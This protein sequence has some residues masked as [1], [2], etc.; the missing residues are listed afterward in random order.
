MKEETIE[1]K[2]PIDILNHKN[3]PKCGTELKVKKYKG[4]IFCD[5]CKIEYTFIVKKRT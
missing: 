5:K 4:Y 3:C 2:K 1:I